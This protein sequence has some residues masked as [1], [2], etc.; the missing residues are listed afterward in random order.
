MIGALDV[1]NRQTSSSLLSGPFQALLLGLCGNTRDG[2]E[3]S[4]T[5]IVVAYKLNT[6]TDSLA[7]SNEVVD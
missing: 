3:C 5:S 1:C 2:I 6:E 4:H 7:I